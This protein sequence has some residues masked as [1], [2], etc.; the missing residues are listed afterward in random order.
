MAPPPWK[1][2][3][4]FVT[5]SPLRISLTLCMN[6]KESVPVPFVQHWTTCPH[7]YFRL[8][9]ESTF[10]VRCPPNCP[11]VS[12][13]GSRH[14]W[15]WSIQTPLKSRGHTPGMPLK[16][17]NHSWVLGLRQVAIQSKILTNEPCGHQV[18]S[19]E[20]F[21]PAAPRALA[22]AD[23]PS[24]NYSRLEAALPRLLRRLLQRAIHLNG[25][26]AHS[27][28]PSVGFFSLSFIFWLSGSI[29]TC[30]KITLTDSGVFTLPVFFLK[31]C[32]VGV[33]VLLTHARP[34][35]KMSRIVW[36]VRLHVRSE[37]TSCHP[38]MLSKVTLGKFRGSHATKILPSS[39]GYH[40]KK[41]ILLRA[42]HSQHKSP[43]PRPTASSREA[44]LAV[45]PCPSTSLL[46]PLLQQVAPH[47]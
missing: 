44:D 15:F 8:H 12:H 27:V 25:D 18:L 5:Y 10:E 11:H 35:S 43:H 20:R 36:E 28:L 45:W 41:L 33:P 26:A 9:Q 30:D 14:G 34:E 31:L 22:D 32:L 3:Q 37:S 40:K 1:L 4:A 21:A 29:N 39:W 46:S 47:Q 24:R 6:P 19:T 2:M 23:T 38:L 17:H 16:R 7:S 42:L 13:F